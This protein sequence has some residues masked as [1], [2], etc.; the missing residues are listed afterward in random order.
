MW[1]VFK[2]APILT[3]LLLLIGAI[4]GRYAHKTFGITKVTV[5]MDAP[6]PSPLPDVEI[7]PPLLPPVNEFNGITC[8]RNGRDCIHMGP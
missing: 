1:R 7:K 5:S 6:L 4:G 8:N 3:I 2:K